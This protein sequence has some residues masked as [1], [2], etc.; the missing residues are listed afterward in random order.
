LEKKEQKLDW[1]DSDD[2]PD[3]KAGATFTSLSIK[4]ECQ[5]ALE[6]IFREKETYDRID[7]K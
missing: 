3:E 2:D 6:M 1:S 7:D 4:E 5:N